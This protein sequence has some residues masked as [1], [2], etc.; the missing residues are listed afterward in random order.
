MQI[1]ITKDLIPYDILD[2]FTNIWNWM[3]LIVIALLW[4]LQG[5]G[6]I[7]M[8]SWGVTSE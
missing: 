6:F 5:L 1:Y 2:S 7:D 3:L 4:L 8:F